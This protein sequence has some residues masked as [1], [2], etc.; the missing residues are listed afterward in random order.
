M[1]SAAVPSPAGAPPVDALV[2]VDVPPCPPAPPAVLAVVPPLPPTLPDELV[3]IPVVTLL[4]EL[5]GP[6][7]LLV[8]VL[9][10]SVA[11][12]LVE[13]TAADAPPTEF[14]AEVASEVAP[15]GLPEV[16]PELSEVPE[17]A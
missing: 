5:L 8:L 9:V 13:V 4:C 11:P 15:L 16:F 2:A 6:P 7:P 12:P 1:S 14:P 3:P 17:S 10:P